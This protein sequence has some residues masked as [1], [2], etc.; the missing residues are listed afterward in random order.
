MCVIGFY[1]LFYKLNKPASRWRSIAL[2]AVVILSYPIY[3]LYIHL[4]FFG[5]ANS[6]SMFFIFIL[7]LM[8]FF[9]SLVLL[10]NNRLRTITV[11]SFV[12]SIFNLAQFPVV[13]FLAAVIYP[14]TNL[15][16]LYEAGYKNP[17]I[18]YGFIIFA[19]IIISI[20]CLLAARWLRNTMLKPPLKLCVFFILL[21]FLFTLVIQVWWEDFSK[22]SSI[23]FLSSF[24]MGV[25]FIVILLS[26]FFIYTRLTA[27]NLSA[28]TKTTENASS[29]STAKVDKYTPFIPHLSRRE[30]EVI[31]AILAGNI[32]HKEL[33]SSLNISVNTVKTHLK[34]IYQATGVSSIAGLSSL[35]HGYTSNHP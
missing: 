12:F 11:S 13:Y 4:H 23:S 30:L 10:G 17:Q 14:A 9:L 1:P 6:Y 3:S 26:L 19:N 8:L 24:F 27:E 33:S 2:L 7:F 16:D 31:E 5:K 29:L 22:V 20:S 21:F 35:F 25:L 28:G 34:H 18:Y 15:N 32:S